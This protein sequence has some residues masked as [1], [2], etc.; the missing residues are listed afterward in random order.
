MTYYESRLQVDAED[1]NELKLKL[2]V[3]K[4]LGINNIFLEPIN[5]KQNRI[6]EW[7]KK[8]KNGKGINLFFR[9]NLKP[10][11]LKDYMNIIRYFHNFEDI[12]SIE[13]GNKE[14]QIRAARDSRV[15]IISFSEPNILKTLTPGIISLTKQNNS[16]IEFSLAPIMV[17]NRSVQSRNFRI[18]YRFIQLALKNNA[19]YVINGNFNTIFDLRHPRAL[20]SVC[21]T[22]LGMSFI[23]ARQG[24]SE[25]VEL[26]LNR[27][28]LRQDKKKIESGVRLL[29]KDSVND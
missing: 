8:V 14:I 17:K 21:N 22:L 5:I 20:I 6:D 13:T 7:K 24:F 25:Y 18:I 27:V 1:L 29:R 19:N 28:Q 2:D 4:K 15:D 10:I 23:K 3:C 12:L 16:Y 11:S 9:F 26:L